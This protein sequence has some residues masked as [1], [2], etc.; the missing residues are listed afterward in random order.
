MLFIVSA[1]ASERSKAEPSK[2][3]S[4]YD[5]RKSDLIRLNIPATPSHVILPGLQYGRSSELLVSIDSAPGPRIERLLQRCA[6]TVF[7]RWLIL[8]LEYMDR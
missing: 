3:T 4:Q 7:A 8:D 2:N 6:G 5:E 1:H